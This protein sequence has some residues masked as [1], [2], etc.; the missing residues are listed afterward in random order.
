MFTVIICDE[1]IIKDCY[2]KYHIYLKPFF[3]NDNFAFCPWNANAETL[4]EAL[5]RL[6]SIIQHKKEWSMSL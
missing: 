1:H 2:H 3:D 5:P 6:K 4:D